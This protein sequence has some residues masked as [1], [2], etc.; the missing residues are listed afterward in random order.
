VTGIDISGEKPGLLPT[1]EWK[2][3][4]FK[5]PA[6]IKSGFPARRSTLEW[7]RAI[8]SSRPCSLR[9]WPASLP[10]RTNFRPRLVIGLRDAS[11]KVKPIAPIPGKRIE[12]VSDA[13]W[14]RVIQGMVGAA[15]YG[16]ARASGKGAAYSIAGKTGTAQVFTVAQNAKY[17]EKTVEE[18]LRDHAWFI[19]FARSTRRG[20]R[21][22]GARRER[23]FRRECCRADCARG[24]GR[25]PA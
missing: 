5:R 2:K 17:D 4:A 13:D 25:L 6:R 12:G 8:C 3:T 21:S 7:V 23:R 20:H 10:A 19:A 9:T 24:H 1:P 18:R 22:R 16:T 14:D 11:G 15:T